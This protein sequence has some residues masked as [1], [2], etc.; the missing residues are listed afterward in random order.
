MSPHQNTPT[1]E[2]RAETILWPTPHIITLMS[3]NPPSAG[4]AAKPY[5]YMMVEAADYL[6]ISE[7]SLRSL[8]AANAITYRR[9]GGKNKGKLCF[10]KEDLD[11]QLEPVGGPGATK[12]NRKGR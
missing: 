3:G 2:F 1:H 5:L 4:K 12:A 7:R 6:R 11:A 8:I 10:Y 9:T